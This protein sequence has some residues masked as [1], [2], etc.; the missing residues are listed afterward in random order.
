MAHQRVRDWPYKPLPA[1]ELRMPD[2]GPWFLVDSLFA[3][4]PSSV[5][6]VQLR[7]SE[8]AFS[9]LSLVINTTHHTFQRLGSIFCFLFLGPLLGKSMRLAWK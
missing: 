4:V 7:L 5:V 8:R 6:A 3:V 2:L 1:R 9:Y